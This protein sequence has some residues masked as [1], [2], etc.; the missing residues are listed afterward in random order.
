MKIDAEGNEISHGYTLVK[1]ATRGNPWVVLAPNG[2]MIGLPKSRDEARKI[3][4]MAEQEKPSDSIKLDL[5]SENKVCLD[6]D[7]AHV[8]SMHTPNGCQVEDCLCGLDSFDSANQDL[9]E[10][11]RVDCH[12]CG[13]LFKP[14]EYEAH[15][16]TCP[17]RKPECNCGHST[18]APDCKAEEC[19]GSRIELP[20]S[21]S[22]KSVARLHGSDVP[23][24]PDRLD[25][26]RYRWKLHDPAPGEWSPASSRIRPCLFRSNGNSLRSMATDAGRKETIQFN[27][28]GF[29]E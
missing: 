2:M 26:Y 7:C 3:V 24:S 1:P 20:L 29:Y 25:R 27:C 5:E 16:Q 23:D 8:I 17:D 15:Y 22:R 11:T 18:N 14:E 28:Q 4:K 19:E 9:Y 13:N 6:K 12:G 21:S 10:S